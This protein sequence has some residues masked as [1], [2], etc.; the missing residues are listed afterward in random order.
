MESANL[1]SCTHNDSPVKDFAG[2]NDRSP[3]RVHG[4]PEEAGAGVGAEL[5]DDA[6]VGDRLSASATSGWS[7]CDLLS[8]STMNGVW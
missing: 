8:M 5:R 3:R 6:I 4:E 2:L 7:A 1:Q